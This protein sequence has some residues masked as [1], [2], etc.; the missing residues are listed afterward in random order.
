MLVV[1]HS[2]DKGQ[3]IYSFWNE[4]EMKDDKTDSSKDSVINQ[5]TNIETDSSSDGQLVRYTI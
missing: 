2:P 3:V 1:L 5:P 4:T